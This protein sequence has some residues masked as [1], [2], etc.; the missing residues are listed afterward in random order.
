VKYRRFSDEG[1]SIKKSAEVVG[2]YSVSVSVARNVGVNDFVDNVNCNRFLNSS[3]NQ[4]AHLRSNFA[5]LQNIL[6]RS[7]FKAVHGKRSIAER[8]FGGEAYRPSGYGDHLS[9]T[10]FRFLY[11]SVSSAKVGPFFL[12]FFRDIRDVR[13]KRDIANIY[14]NH[15]QKF[16]RQ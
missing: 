9:G 15:N 8:L 13:D 12:F 2:G 5:R 7:Y 1:K 10:Y 4:L 3:K 6:C 16:N 14:K 11:E